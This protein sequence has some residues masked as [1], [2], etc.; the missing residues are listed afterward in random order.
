MDDRFARTREF[1]GEE[2]FARVRAARVTVAGLGGVGS[3]AAVALA[4]NGLGRLLLV[5]FDMVT[6]S[7]LNRSPFAGPGAVGLPKADVLRAHLGETCPDTV[8]ECRRMFIDP[9][10]ARD[11]L[12]PAPDF[13]V[14]AIDSLNP[15]V[16]LIAECL[17][18][19]IPLVSSMG[20]SRR[21]DPSTVRV[22]DISLTSGCPLARKVRQHLA[23]RGVRSGF[24]CVF[25]ADAPQA[26]PG[27]PDASESLEG[28]GRVR[29]RLPGLGTI[30][31]IF[32][33]ACASEVLTALAEGRGRSG[34]GNVWESNP[35][36]MV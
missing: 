13:L 19:R 18:A 36:R 31:G 24:R 29:R 21:S 16:A 12:D 9:S 25:S 11:L 5:D 35:P 1:L 7:S 15:K 22:A 4:R 32:G 3:H 10:C 20:A 14:D 8:C 2:G 17:A 34:G 33:Y 30:P 28:R 26:P 6:P 23:R 27:P